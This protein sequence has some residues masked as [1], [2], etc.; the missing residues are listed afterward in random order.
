MAK[1]SPNQ[2]KTSMSVNP[3]W[4]R[5]GS[6]IRRTYEFK[7][8]PAAIKFVNSV[9]RLAEKAGHHPDVDIRWNRVTLALTTHDE[10]GLTSKDFSLAAKCDNVVLPK[11]KATGSMVEEDEC[12][13]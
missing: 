4:R 5:R 2:I 13:F 10:G 11:K 9:A 3:S 1:L 7:D 12:P 6:V 8:F